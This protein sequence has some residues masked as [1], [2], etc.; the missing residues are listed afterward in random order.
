MNT[1]KYSSSNFE[2]YNS[3]VQIKASKILWN[4]DRIELGQIAVTASRMKLPTV[5]N[6]KRKVT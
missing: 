1:E 3:D 5:T 2:K 4:L 6:P